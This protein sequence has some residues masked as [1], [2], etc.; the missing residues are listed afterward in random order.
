MWRFIGGIAPDPEAPGAGSFIINPL[1]GDGLSWSKA[2]HHTMRGPVSVEWKTQDGGLTLR[3][4]LPPNTTAL[5]IVPG[6]SAADVTE[7]GCPLAKASGVS[8][9]GKAPG[10]CAVRVQSGTYSF[11]S[12]P[13]RK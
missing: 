10:G 4:S 5:V 7:S 8:V 12:L 6:A 2:R 13:R 1:P 9:V 11:T 3:V